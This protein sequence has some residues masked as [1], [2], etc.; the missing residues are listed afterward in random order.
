M[1]SSK[2]PTEF[3]SYQCIYNVQGKF[4]ITSRTKKQ[5]YATHPQEKKVISGDQLQADLPI[6]INKEGFK[7][8]SMIMLK[9]VKENILIQWKGYLSKEIKMTKKQLNFLF[10]K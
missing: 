8:T 1:D 5:E 2:E 9:D 6:V 10:Q 7:A 4:Q 3:K